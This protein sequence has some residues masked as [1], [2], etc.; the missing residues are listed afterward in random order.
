MVTVTVRVTR[1]E[2]SFIFDF[3]SVEVAF[4]DFSD[5]STA[6]Q[7]CLPTFFFFFL[8]RVSFVFS[9]LSLPLG[10]FSSFR[11]SNM[12]HICIYLQGIP[13]AERGRRGERKSTN[14]LTTTPTP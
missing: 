7:K 14:F 5:F 11:T 12:Q 3:A 9:V 8:L 10:F 4:S 6:S 2:L 1:F 13:Q